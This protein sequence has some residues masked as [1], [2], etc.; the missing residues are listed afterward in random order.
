MYLANHEFHHI[1]FLLCANILQWCTADAN[2][3]KSARNR[4]WEEKIFSKS[5]NNNKTRVPSLQ[6]TVA[7]LNVHFLCKEK[8][9]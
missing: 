9:S 3:E 4:G 6:L 2:R 7:V 8:A 5:T 1:L